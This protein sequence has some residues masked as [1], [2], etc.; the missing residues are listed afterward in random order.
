MCIPR[1]NWKAPFLERC[2]PEHLPELQLQRFGHNPTTGG[3]DT[4]GNGHDQ[5]ITLKNV[6]LTGR[7]T[8][9][10]VLINNLIASGKQVIDQQVIPE[11]P[12]TGLFTG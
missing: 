4:A 7:L 8:D 3:Q 2:R 12:L 1:Y 5:L 9:Q 11:S 10:N 6:D